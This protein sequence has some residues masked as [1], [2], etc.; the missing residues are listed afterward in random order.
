MSVAHNRF[1]HPPQTT[2]A[3]AAPFRY[4]VWAGWLYAVAGTAVPVAAL[5]WAWAM[6]AVDV[7]KWDDHALKAFLVALE[8][9]T[10]PLGWFRQV[11]KQHNEHRIAYD[12]LL[13]WADYSVF[14]KLSFKRLMIYGD[15]SLLALVGLFGVLLRQYIKPWYLF[16]PP[17]A[18][19]IVSLAQWENLY[20]AL[21]SIQNFSIVGWSLACLYVLTHQPKIG[22]A[23]GLAIEIGRAHV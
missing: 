21:S 13:T 4:P 17:V 5:A 6:L 20:W 14:G 23:I 11:V 1:P 22:W 16:L 15:L 10:S 19:F 7:P 8:T 18:L 9:E 3:A 2:S 12:R